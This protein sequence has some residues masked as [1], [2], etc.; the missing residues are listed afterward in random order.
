MR[1]AIQGY[2]FTVPAAKTNREGAMSEIHS[3]SDIHNYIESKIG[4]SSICRS[5]QYS[6][7]KI[8]Q[9][10]LS[11]NQTKNAS[12]ISKNYL[13]LPLAI[14]YGIYWLKSFR[15]KNKPLA[16]TEIVTL[17]TNRT[18][19][20]NRGVHHS[21]YFENICSLIEKERLTRLATTHTESYFDFN[22]KNLRFSFPFPDSSERAM[23][24]EVI[25]VLKKAKF[26][27]I[28]NSGEIVYLQSALAVFLEEFRFYYNI[29]KGQP[30]RKI[31]FTC[32]YHKEGLIAAAKV[33]GIE[34]IELQ[35]GL[36][37]KNDIYYVYPKQYSQGLEN[38]FFADRLF[39]FGSQWKNILLQGFEFDERQIVVAGD[40]S[41]RTNISRIKSSKK[42]NVILITSQKGIHDDF[43]G[44]CRILEKFIVQ[45]P[46]WEVMVK[47]HPFELH[48]EIYE[49]Q[50]QTPFRIAKSDE[51]LEDLFLLAKI[52]ITIYS[53]TLYDAI[54][55][56][57]VN[58]SL[59]N[60]GKSRDYAKDIVDDGIALPL[61][62]TDDPIQ[63]FEQLS[64]SENAE[65]LK[66]DDFYSEL[67]RKL[68]ADILDC[69]SNLDNAQSTYNN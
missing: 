1:F 65:S 35:H 27:G 67:N 25:Y 11:Y 38:A 61:E 6:F 24:R 41:F 3:F 64:S 51:I 9:H 58:F 19:V 33:L 46:G 34:S 47:L 28:F 55:Y 56:G 54:G 42:Q 66:R 7:I 50:L 2:D 37:A 68:M 62:I 39:V 63:I 30:T 26:S 59:Q 12:K 13:G 29:F 20:D 49:Q 32:H 22:I 36:I 23:I 16:L 48:R 43:I 57:L 4:D 15:K 69:R 53:T 5:K 21:V 17:E 8:F 10:A 40:Y 18:I 45:H 60:Y 52:H 14:Q 44:Y 31:I